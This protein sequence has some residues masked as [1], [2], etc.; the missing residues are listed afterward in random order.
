MPTNPLL[1]QLPT[2]A[3]TTLF[4]A[5]ERVL[6]SDPVL[7]A[8]VKTWRTYEGRPE[9][10]QPP[11]STGLPWVRLTP[12]LGAD[13]WWASSTMV[14]RLYLDAEIVIEGTCADDLLN[15]WGAVERAVYP[16]DA[17]ARLAIQ[18]RLRAEGKA[19]TGLVGFSRPQ[20]AADPE[21][22]QIEARAWLAVEYRF[23]T[24]PTAPGF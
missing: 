3:T 18:A 1:K 7:K 17:A 8:T 10:V 15:L 16:N 14:G 5:L 6:R 4:R 23:D 20:F 2:D 11:A 12:R 24:N 13:D 9:D 21:A 22:N 19:H